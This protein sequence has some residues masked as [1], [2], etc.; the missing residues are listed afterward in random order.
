MKIDSGWIKDIVFGVATYFIL[1]SMFAGSSRWEMIDH[2]YTS[3][4]LGTL[5]IFGTINAWIL[6][7]RFLDRK[8]YGMFVLFTAINIC[9]GALFNHLLFDRFIDYLLPGYYFISYYDYTDL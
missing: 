4:F 8:K 3:I 5:I 6:Q 2:I 9:L 7:P 1:L